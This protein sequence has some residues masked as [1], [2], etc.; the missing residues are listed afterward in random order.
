MDRWHRLVLSGGVALPWRSRSIIVLSLC[1]IMA[2]VTVFAVRWSSAPGRGTP[3]AALD[4]HEGRLERA[5]PLEQRAESGEQVWLCLAYAPAQDIH[6]ALILAV[7]TGD[8]LRAA[9][10]LA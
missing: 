10:L 2:V 9:K 8:E 5:V 3:C 7:N 1:A 6:G 4:V